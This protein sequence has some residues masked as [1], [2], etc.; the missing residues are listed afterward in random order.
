VPLTDSST[1]NGSNTS[2]LNLTDVTTSNAGLYN[3]TITNKAGSLTSASVKL[4]VE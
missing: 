2:I 3:V 1:I 4:T